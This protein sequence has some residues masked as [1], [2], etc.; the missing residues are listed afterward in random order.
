MSIEERIDTLLDRKRT[1]S[2]TVL[3]NNEASLTELSDTE[4]LDLVRLRDRPDA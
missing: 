1:L 3:G 2:E 4:L